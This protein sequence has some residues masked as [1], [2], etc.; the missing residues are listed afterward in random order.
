[1]SDQSGDDAREGDS[2]DSPE[3]AEFADR[4]RANDAGDES[5]D[6]EREWR[7]GVDDVGPDGIT[8]DTATPEEEPIEPGDVTIEH[9]AFV[10]LGVALTVGTLLVGF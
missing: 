9:A 6:G 1:M 4:S 2:P 3:S 7:F 10:V 8:E 5:A